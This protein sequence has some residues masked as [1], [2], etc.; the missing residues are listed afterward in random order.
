MLLRNPV[1]LVHL[2]HRA[3][4]EKPCDQC[5]DDSRRAWVGPLRRAASPSWG[6]TFQE[7][8]IE[9]LHWESH[10]KMVICG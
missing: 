9:H 7:A 4:L 6:V 2:V 5:Y 1:D 8:P 10:R 3:H